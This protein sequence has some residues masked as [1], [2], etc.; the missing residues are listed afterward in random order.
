MEF[1][2]V[3]ELIGV[4]FWCRHLTNDYSEA[5]AMCRQLEQSTGHI[6]VVVEV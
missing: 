5:C 2:A 4:I 3:K 6:C 1:F